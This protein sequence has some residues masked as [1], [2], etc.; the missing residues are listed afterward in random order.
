MHIKHCISNVISCFEIYDYCTEELAK[1]KDDF[2]IVEIPNQKKLKWLGN[3]AQFGFFIQELI[4]KG[5]LDKPTRSYSKDA[6]LYLSIFEIDTKVATLAK[7]ISSGENQ[8][9]LSVKNR[10]QI[11]IPHKDKI[12]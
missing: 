10:N 1:L 7:E 11:R 6:N 8:N 3:S 2:Q 9:S 12:S 5:Y 4:G